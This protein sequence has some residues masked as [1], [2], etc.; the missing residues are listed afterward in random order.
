[1]KHSAADFGLL[2]ENLPDGIVVMDM[3][4]LAI[5][6]INPAATRLLGIAPDETQGQALPSTVF[7]N[8]TFEQLYDIYKDPSLPHSFCQN[9]PTITGNVL[10][11]HLVRLTDDRCA[12]IIKD[13]TRMQQLE[14]MRTDFVGNVSHELRTPL[15]VILGYLENF[16]L[17]DDV[18]PAWARGLKLMREQAIRMN[19][20][21]ND[22]LMLSR[23]ESDETKPMA[24]V[25]MPRLLMQVFDQASASNQA[26]H[27]IDIHLD[28]DKNILGIEAYLYSAII[29]LVL[30]AIKYTPSGGMIDIIYEEDGGNVHLSVTDNGI[31]ISGEHLGR[32]TERFY[33]VDSGRSR[34]TGGTGL[35]LA[36]VKH[37]LNKH[38]ARLEIS[39]EEGVGSTFHIIFPKSQTIST[40]TLQTQ[41][42]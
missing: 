39:S 21:I 40:Q 31:G 11:L 26:G 18:K 35:G 34:A 15:T 10:N 20:L 6:Y 17:T 16:T 32:L 42:I 41:A 5:E 36:I 12:V 30:N 24:E 27:L 23:L 3:S 1:M 22:L 4:R 25:N 29:N 14:Q 8:S 38:N 37:V 2:V 33:R 13:H 9:H 19:D 7:A 28:T